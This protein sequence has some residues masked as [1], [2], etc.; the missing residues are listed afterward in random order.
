MSG[1]DQC[2]L[3]RQSY[4]WALHS[5]CHT[6]AVLL[7]TIVQW[8]L[9]ESRG[10]DVVSYRGEGCIGGSI[11]AHMWQLQ[12]DRDDYKWRCRQKKK[13]GMT[14]C[15]QC[16]VTTFSILL[17]WPAFLVGVSLKIH[18]VFFASH[19]VWKSFLFYNL[20]IRCRG[21]RCLLTIT[22]LRNN[23]KKLHKGI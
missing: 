9:Q 13:K 23:I 21:G 4:L 8:L 14:F 10:S 22:K 3:Q 20:L 16:S 5:D 6:E 2:V 12:R 1:A 15:F 19:Y 18:L 7:L 17:K 11:S